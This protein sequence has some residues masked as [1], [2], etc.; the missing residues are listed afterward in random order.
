MRTSPTTPLGQSLS[1]F[2]VVG[3]LSVGTDLVVLFGLRSALHAPLWLATLIAYSASL[4]VNYSLNHSWVFASQ[5]D[6]R[7]TLVRYVLLV[8][9]N[10]ASTLGFV[11]GL[12]AL[13]AFYL[14]AKLVAVAVNAVINFTGFRWWVFR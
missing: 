9:V 13:G 7:R 12:T 2:V 4:A 10:V 3:A 6:H 14:L 5:H 11:L 8:A 1:R